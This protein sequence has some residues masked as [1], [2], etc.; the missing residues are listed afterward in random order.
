MAGHAL[1]RGIVARQEMTLPE[2]AESL[3]ILEPAGLDLGARDAEGR[4]A[5][6]IVLACPPDGIEAK[7]LI[8]VFKKFGTDIRQ[9]GL[10]RADLHPFAPD[11]KA[12]AGRGGYVFPPARI[13]S[14]GKKGPK[15]K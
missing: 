4:T 14:G 15:P 3:R 7:N 1:A 2:I 13:V 11:R 12:E 6:G 10:S 8:A 5:L 9:E